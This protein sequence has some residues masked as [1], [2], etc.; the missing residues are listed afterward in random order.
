MNIKNVLKSIAC[1]DRNPAACMLIANKCRRHHP[2]P[3]HGKGKGN[4]KGRKP[5]KSDSSSEQSDDSDL[6][7]NPAGPRGK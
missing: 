1:R 4:G 7:S 3:K 6:D 2:P 5:K